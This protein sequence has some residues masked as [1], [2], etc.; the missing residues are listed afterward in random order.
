MSL[1]N[2]EEQIKK[3]YS[4]L[5]SLNIKYQEVKHPQLYTE[6][7]NNKYG[8]KF[9]GSLC[10]N[11]FIQNK[12]ESNYYLIIVEIN[13]RLNLKNIQEI[14]NE[15]RLSFGKEQKLIQELNTTPGNLSIFNLANIQKTN[16]K[17]I[18]DKNLLKLKKIGFHPNINN[19][20]VFF[21]GKHIEKV[22]KFYNIEYMLIDM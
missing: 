3:V 8:I 1:L 4:L 11:L 18:V 14:L 13:K 7:D 22:L 20:T 16:I 17:F 19:R 15:T 21:E 5:E 9:D 12:N 2:Q 10:K 6:K